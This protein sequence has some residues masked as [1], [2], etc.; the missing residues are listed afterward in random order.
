M[1]QATKT[2]NDTLIKTW[3]RYNTN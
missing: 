2:M 3:K 1:T